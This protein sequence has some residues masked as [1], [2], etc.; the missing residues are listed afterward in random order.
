MSIA[1]EKSETVVMGA[2]YDENGLLQ[3]DGDLAREYTVELATASPEDIRVVVEPVATNIP[4]EAIVVSETDL[5]FPA[6]TVR[7]SVSVSLADADFGFDVPVAVEN[8]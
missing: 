6:G 5:W 1:G 2:A 4:A 7:R 8:P 3:V